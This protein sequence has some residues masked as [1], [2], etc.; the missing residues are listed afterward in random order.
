[1]LSVAIAS[2]IYIPILLWRDIGLS[3]LDLTAA[4]YAYKPAFVLSK[5]I[6]AFSIISDFGLTLMS[7]IALR[8][9]QLTKV[10][11]LSA[12]FL[13][14][15]GSFAG[16]ASTVRLAIIIRIGKTKSDTTMDTIHLAEWALIEVGI[17]VG[18]SNMALI[19]PFFTWVWEKF[20]LGSNAATTANASAGIVTVKHGDDYGKMQGMRMLVDDEALLVKV[21]T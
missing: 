4:V 1:M 10:A 12:A 13:L 15:L 3:S 21:V 5:L 11:K 2:S 19:R 6:S 14:G 7:F 16:A 18:V 20:N 9:I 8:H 17:C